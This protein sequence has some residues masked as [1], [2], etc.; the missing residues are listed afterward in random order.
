DRPATGEATGGEQTVD[1]RP[2]WVRA[3][4]P[5]WALDENVRQG[6]PPT[7]SIRAGQYHQE[8]AR[9]KP[10]PWADLI[11]PKTPEEIDREQQHSQRMDRQETMYEFRRNVA[12]LLGVP[13]FPSMEQRIRE[14]LGSTDAEESQGD[15]SRQPEETTPGATRSAAQLFD[16]WDRQFERDIR[17]GEQP[18]SL[19]GV[20]PQALEAYLCLAAVRCKGAPPEA[21]IYAGAALANLL[22]S[23]GEMTPE[24]VEEVLNVAE[25]GLQDLDRANEIAATFLPDARLATVDDPRRAELIEEINRI[26][27]NETV[28]DLMASRY[29]PE[30]HATAPDGT[31]RTEPLPGA[32]PEIGVLSFPGDYLRALRDGTIP[33]VELASLEANCQEIA[34][35]IC[36]AD[37]RIPG[38]SA[39]PNVLASPERQA[40]LDALN[41]ALSR[42]WSVW[43]AEPQSDATRQAW[44]DV[45][46][47]K[48][49]LIESMR[50]TSE[51]EVP[52]AAGAAVPVQ[53]SEVAQLTSRA[54][55]GV[56]DAVFRNLPT[57]TRPDGTPLTLPE[58]AG[59][60]LGPDRITNSDYTFRVSEVVP[61][62]EARQNTPEQPEV[63]ARLV[64]SGETVP[65]PISVPVPTAVPTPVP[66]GETTEG[67]TEPGEP[68]EQ[69]AT[70]TGARGGGI[71]VA[72][73]LP[74]PEDPIGDMLAGG[75][76][77]PPVELPDLNAPGGRPVDPSEFDPNL[78]P[79]LVPPDVDGL[80]QETF[81]GRDE[82]LEWI[83]APNGVPGLFTSPLG[84]EEIVTTGETPA[85]EPAPTPAP[86]GEPV[87]VPPV[88]T[89]Q[90]PTR[91]EPPRYAPLPGGGSG[92]VVDSYALS[93]TGNPRDVAGAVTVVRDERTGQLVAS[94]QGTRVRNPD[95]TE[96]VMFPQFPGAERV[97]YNPAGQTVAV[98]R[99][100]EGQT[101]RVTPTTP[102]Q[103]VTV[104]TS[105]GTTLEFNGGGGQN[106]VPGMAYRDP[107][108]GNPTLEEWTIFPA[109]NLNYDTGV[110]TYSAQVPAGYENRVD[111]T[112]PGIIR[113]QVPAGT[114]PTTVTRTEQAFTPY[115]PPPVTTTAPA[116]VTPVTP[117]PTPTPT[118]TDPIGTPPP[119]RT[120]VTP[121]GRQ[122]VVT[123]QNDG[124]Y[125][126]EVDG[127]GVRVNPTPG[128]QNQIQQPNLAEQGLDWLNRNVVQP[129]GRAYRNLEE[130]G[131]EQMRTTVT[132]SQPLDGV[133]GFGVNRHRVWFMDGGRAVYDARTGERLEVEEGNPPQSV[134]TTQLFM[135]GLG[136]VFPASPLGGSAVPRTAPLKLFPVR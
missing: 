107:V 116:P 93:G 55:T 89:V 10:S 33:P 100:P 23:N 79:D 88:Q 54:Q 130:Q 46:A 74:R 37:Y 28:A 98:F 29:L 34:R 129:A 32:P 27:P 77:S 49:R 48:K 94:V 136:P 85:A 65:V 72:P 5:E 71:V 11:P 59:A 115:T 114:R 117:T 131:R 39:A 125:T 19:Q 63:S 3:G 86:F 60:L 111:L 122:V 112:Q 30:A 91:Q 73:E 1:D 119:T 58:F 76:P 84:Q 90:Q 67:A 124:S 16:I 14:V 113:L 78:V 20:S 121:D 128:T 110:R 109:S 105:P 41:T 126:G 47:A 15:Q 52:L 101:G 56:L 21:T 17:L 80:G 2:F 43:Q 12:V 8:T 118:R 31:P 62:T 50:G 24:G 7:Y 70:G 35:A 87:V 22:G 38:S 99:L 108:S 57:R 127:I 68:G 40:D 123:R 81:P 106:A 69:P 120:I 45:E 83:L 96:T 75:R 102:V 95:G 13:A 82:E 25:Q 66:G 61:T 9:G 104:R 97:G 6:G 134:N 92:V 51:P 44:A 64:P 26:A 42:Y 133:L 53:R 18:L 103:R 4:L 135:N 132:G 36:E